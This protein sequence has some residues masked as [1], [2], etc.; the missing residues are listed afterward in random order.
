MVMF[1]CQGGQYLP[2]S[3]YQTNLIDY[4]NAGGRVFATHFGY[5]WLY[6]DA[7]FSETADWDVN[8]Q[9]EFTADPETANVVETI[10]NEGAV[11][12]TGV[13]LA[14][15]LKDVGASTTLG[16]LPLGT[17]RKDQDGVTTGSQ[18]WLQIT[19]DRYTTPTVMQFSF[20]TPVNQP[21]A[22]T[23]GRVMFSEYHTED[24]TLTAQTLFP[25]ECSKGPMTAQEKLLEF[26]LFNLTADVT[27][28]EQPQLTVG[29]S[30][31][32]TKLHQGDSADAVTINVT[33]SGTTLAATPSLLA[34]V[35]LP[36]GVT[37]KSLKGADVGT[38]WICDG[39]KLRCTR[40][41]ALQPGAADPIA[42]VASVESN[43]PV[44]AGSAITATVAGGGLLSAVTATKEVTITGRPII[45]W[46]GPKAIAY[47]TSLSARQLNAS[48][49]VPGKFTY[50]P[51]NGKVLAAGAQTLTV[52]FTP[53]DTID[54]ESATAK[55]TL[56]VNRAELTFAAK[57][58]SVA[59]EKPIPKLA[60]TVTG[61]VNHDTSA[62][63]T[64]DPSETTAAKE[65]SKPGTYPIDIAKGTLKASNYAFVF[66]DGELT[67]TPV[68]TAVETNRGR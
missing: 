62:V 58:E 33:N 29:V 60:Y 1:A 21:E 49:T 23:C 9:A 37:A 13:E 44:S 56:Q 20:N 57:S 55:V 50:A 11:Y 27:A 52:T 6:D 18:A 26:S 5:V 31:Q 40:N 48:T 54:F 68:P 47:G 12:P 8:Q 59:Y 3:A 28:M 36:P 17:L 63:L 30:S 16:Q 42:V 65:G 15:W 66:K 35:A 43:A 19:D 61:F 2:Q 25:A 39:S 10:T 22:K 45:A 24:Q 38:G 7:P 51:A 64:G 4:A 14:Q 46:P 53:T 34:I 67:I 32:T 41:N